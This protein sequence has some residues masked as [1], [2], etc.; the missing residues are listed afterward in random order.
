MK[1]KQ[2][3]IALITIHSCLINKSSF[4][5]CPTN[6]FGVINGLFDS[7]LFNVS[8]E[9]KFLSD[10]SY[11]E[12]CDINFLPSTIAI[13]RKPNSR[14]INEFVGYVYLIN[15]IKYYLES[16]EKSK[17]YITGFT[18]SELN[19]FSTNFIEKEFRILEDKLCTDNIE[20]NRYDI[21]F[22][23][24]NPQIYLQKIRKI[25]LTYGLY[26]FVLFL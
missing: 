23:R 2:I 14:S 9:I 24:V 10:S 8:T 13:L 26:I 20:Y 12:T 3:L 17:V 1:S 7:M 21:G 16:S 11:A 22:L 18:S 19:I 6:S 15:K 5:Q 25:E 4:S